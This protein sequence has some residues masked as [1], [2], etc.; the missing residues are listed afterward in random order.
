MKRRKRLGSSMHRFRGD[1]ADFGSPRMPRRPL[2][3]RSLMLGLAIPAAVIL[4]SL[5]GSLPRAGAQDVICPAEGTPAPEGTP[6]PMSGLKIGASVAYLSTPF[7]AGLK[8]GLDDGARQFGFEYDLRDGKSDA[9]TEAANIQN[10]IANDVDVILLAPLNEGTIPAIMQANQAGIPVIEVNKTAGFYSD[11]VEVVTFVGA[12][13]REFGRLQARLLDE[14]FAGEPA[15]IGYVMG[16]PGVTTQMRA[17]GFREVLAEQPAYTIVAEASDDFDSAQALAV[18]KDLLER[19]PEG[20]LDVIVM[21]GP[22]GVA[23]AQFALQNGREDVQFILGEYPAEVRQA[24]LGGSVLG[25]IFQDPYPQA[26]EA[27][28]MAWLLLSGQEAAIPRPHLLDLQIVTANNAGDT[29]PAW[30]C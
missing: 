27:V 7:Y 21:Q 19:F 20:E 26:F 9:A 14:V 13:D 24:I 5:A 30:G 12:N 3:R 23:A 16:R 18:T 29:P 25:T 17:E 4:P 22:E 6:L 8:V 11:E 10:F 15:R 2:L 28:R 1:R